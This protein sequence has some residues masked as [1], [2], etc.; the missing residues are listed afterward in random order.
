MTR[1]VGIFYF[2]GTGNTRALSSLLCN[3]FLEKGIACETIDIS[4]LLKNGIVPEIEKY[5]L[6]GIGY[7]VYGSNCPNPVI[8]FVDTLSLCNKPVFLFKDG[9]TLTFGG[10]PNTNIKEKLQ[11][12]EMHV[13]YED[14]YIMPANSMRKDPPEL[15]KCL[16]NIALFK[17]H[18]LVSDLVDHKEKHQHNPALVKF[19]AHIMSKV[20]SNISSDFSSGLVA[21]QKCIKC[22]KCIR[23]C[24]QNNVF[25][26][27]GQ[28]RF[29]N[30]C[31][32]CLKCIYNCPVKAIEST[33]VKKFVLDEFYNIDKIMSDDN[34]KVDI[35][36]IKRIKMPK[37]VKA[38]I[39]RYTNPSI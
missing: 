20:E 23:E 36:K 18:M 4:P 8:S 6:I 16:M 17:A 35:E 37:E 28:I 19:Y 12:K 25:Q 7:P 38:Y 26:A 24:P 39:G 10:G 3:Q 34:I 1:N 21:N 2:S 5:D 11:A 33:K 29:G 15:I 14:A 31:L 13:I 27:E 30:D 32:M 22:S 9:G